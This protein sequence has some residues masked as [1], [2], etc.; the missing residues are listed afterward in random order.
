VWIG[1]LNLTD[2]G[3]FHPDTT[4]LHG[5][6]V[7]HFPRNDNCEI[8]YCN[9]EVTAACDCSVCMFCSAL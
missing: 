8:V 3:S 2:K 7:L 1:R 4:E 9:L 5:G 6:I